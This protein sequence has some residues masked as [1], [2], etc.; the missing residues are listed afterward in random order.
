METI[1]SNSL[2][3]TPVSSALPYV[4]IKD[5]NYADTRHWN[6]FVHSVG[7]YEQ[8]IHLQEIQDISLPTKAHLERV[9]L[10]LQIRIHEVEESLSKF[11]FDDAHFAQEDLPPAI[12]AASDRFRKFLRQFYEK[13]YQN[14]PIK[15]GKPGLWLDRSIVNRL[16]TDFSALYEYIVDR[17][18][19]WDDDK[20]DDRKRPNLLKSA[21]S[22]NFGL[23]AEDFRMLLGVF[24]NFDCRLNTSN[25]PH[26]YPLLP[27]S[28]PAPPVM[29]K[30]VFRG[31]KTDKVRESRVIHAYAEASNASRIGIEYATNSLVKAFVQFEKSD[32]PGDVDPREARREHWI[33]IYCVLQTLAGISVDVPHLSFKDDVT[34]FLNVRLSGLPPWDPTGKVFEDV[35]RE[36]SHCWTTAESWSEG[37]YE[38][39]TSP[40]I[41]PYIETDG[42]E[43]YNSRPLSPEMQIHPLSPISQS[44][45]TFFDSNRHTPM[46][47]QDAN[48]SNHYSWGDSTTDAGTSP[49]YSLPPKYL[50]FPAKFAATAGISRHDA[51]PIRSGRALDRDSQSQ[52]TR[53]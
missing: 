21:N 23:D 29:K 15:S 46:G 6:R 44:S 45:F 39:W 51:L 16:Q 20:D 26:P 40:K 2:N 19:M 35:G 50:P 10:E 27:P 33:I 41:P 52:R 34:Y 28:V 49:D 48:E 43:S 3:K 13:D 30:S 25:I 22:F 17:N 36:Q 1:S 9:H 5:C 53:R 32:Y 7:M 47:E 37:H 12:R 8:L 31:K 11:Y 38:R 42:H 18:V 4:L 14:W 24:Q